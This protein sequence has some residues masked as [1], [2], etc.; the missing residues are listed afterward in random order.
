MFEVS[1]LVPERVIVIHNINQLNRKQLASGIQK[2]NRM[3]QTSNHIVHCILDNRQLRTVQT[4]VSDILTTCKRLPFTGWFLTIN[5][6]FAGQHLSNVLMTRYLPRRTQ[7]FSTLQTAL[8]FLQDVD[9][10]LSNLDYYIT[11]MTSR[12]HTRQLRK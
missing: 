3:M 6:N 10:S 9:M 11:P 7:S 12:K 1:W 4:S 2:I 8:R 5:G